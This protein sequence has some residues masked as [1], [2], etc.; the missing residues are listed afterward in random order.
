MSF[1][2]PEAECDELRITLNVD[3]K[4]SECTT[5]LSRKE[6]LMLRI[7]SA[8]TRHLCDIAEASKQNRC[9]CVKRRAFQ[10]LHLWRLN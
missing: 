8:N 1:D 9:M 4:L 7:R 5:M 6:N 10:I 2:I 3:H